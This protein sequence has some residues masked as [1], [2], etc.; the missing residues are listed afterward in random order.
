MG[1]Q[2]IATSTLAMTKGD[3]LEHVIVCTEA[4]HFEVP[5]FDIPHRY[6]AYHNTAPDEVVERLR[7]ATI[8]ISTIVRILPHHL[9]HAPNLKLLIISATSYDWVDTA[10][11][12]ARGVDVVHCPG[13]NVPAVAEH[14][15][16]LYF[17]VRRRIVA[18]ND[19]TRGSD[20]W[21]ERGTLTRALYSDGL[22]P[23]SCAQETMGIVGYGALGKRIEMLAGAI[24]F[25][26]IVIAERKGAENLRERRMEFN[27]LLQK[28]TVLMICCPK[29]AST[30][31]LI[32]EE[33]MAKMRKDNLII[34]I[35]RGGVVDEAALVKALR[36]QKIAGAA[37]DVFE[38][39]PA[40][41]GKNPLL[42]RVEDGEDPIPNLTVSPHIAWCAG[43]TIKA[44]QRLLKEGIERWYKQDPINLI[45]HKG[46]ILK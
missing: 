12:A 9:E 4:C 18:L 38:I 34:N 23:R 22:P 25:G 8:V 1:E 19:L 11:F 26:E 40:I 13:S 45:V 2:D 27:E 24:G 10:A 5:K 42:P 30:I 37:T 28:C 14:A 3:A 32:G 35:A 36:G 39:E 7:E 41:R 20:A 29:D 21:A 33:E 6:V 15:L 44:L 46:K 31:G 17:A 16:G 43:M